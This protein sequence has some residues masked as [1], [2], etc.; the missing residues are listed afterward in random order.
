MSPEQK[1]RAKD[2]AGRII[3]EEI[4]SFLDSSTSPVSGGKFKKKLKDGKTRSIL[5]E[6]G[7][8]RDSI[9]FKKAEG[10]S[11][12]VGIWNSNET[13]KAWNHN[14][15]ET[16][17][18]RQFI[19]NDSGKA[20]TFK[21]RINDRV[22]GMIESVRETGGTPKRNLGDIMEEFEID[23][24]VPDQFA[25]AGAGFSINSLLDDMFGTN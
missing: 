1:D 8:M 11:I 12:E 23:I 15:G 21:G 7:T 22:N 3:V 5:F 25:T 17:P 14:K 2:E 13:P 16:V 19:P 18:V 9:E 4:N 20:S 24:T 6:F 10:D